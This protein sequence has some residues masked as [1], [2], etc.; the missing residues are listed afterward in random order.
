M[1]GKIPDEIKTLETSAKITFANA[2]DAEF[3]FLLRERRSSTLKKM[4]EATIEVE[5]NILVADKLK[6]RGDRDR[7]RKKKNCLPLLA[8]HLI[9][10]YMK[11]IR[12]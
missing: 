7:K 2:F 12:R 10:R 1:Y 6:S 3:S 9:L 5:T 4:T 8:H 11:W